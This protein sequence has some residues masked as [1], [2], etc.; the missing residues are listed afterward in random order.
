[1]LRSEMEHPQVFRRMFYMYLIIDVIRGASIL[2]MRYVQ[3]QY[4]TT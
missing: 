2:R 1:M 3:V 4:S